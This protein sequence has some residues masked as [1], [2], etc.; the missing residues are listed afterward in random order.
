[1]LS[2]STQKCPECGHVFTKGPREL[3]PLEEAGDVIVVELDQSQIRLKRKSEEREART[4]EAL[5]ELG[6]QRGYKPGWAY[7]KH[8]ERQIKRSSSSTANS[9]D[10][11]SRP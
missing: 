4:L 8:K 2:V 9:L 6:R 5:Q 3:K 7:I 1:M 10:S 11:W